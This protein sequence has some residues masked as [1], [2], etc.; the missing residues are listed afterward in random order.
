[1]VAVYIEKMIAVDDA[2]VIDLRI[3]MRSADD[4]GKYDDDRKIHG[5]KHTHP[6]ESMRSSPMT[7]KERHQP[8]P[9]DNLLCEPDGEAEYYIHRHQAQQI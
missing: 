2:W 7:C 9:Y 1:M 5:R 8:H 4:H 3:C 6:L